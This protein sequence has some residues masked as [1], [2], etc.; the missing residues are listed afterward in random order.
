MTFR[1]LFSFFF[2]FI[3]HFQLLNTHTISS[4]LNPLHGI[5]NIVVTSFYNTNKCISR[6]LIFF[7]WIYK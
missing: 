4:V 7:T 6:F 2:I 3:F 5:A 1:Q